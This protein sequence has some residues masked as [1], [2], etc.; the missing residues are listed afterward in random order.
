MKNIDFKR[1]PS[2]IARYRDEVRSRV[3]DELP[4]HVTGWYNQIARAQAEARE[5]ERRAITDQEGWRKERERLLADFRAS[6]GPFPPHLVEIRDEGSLTTPDAVIRKVLFSAAPD[7]WVPA[8][9]YLPHG[10]SAASRVPAIASPCGHGIAGKAAYAKRAIQLVRN[11][12]A[13]ITFDFIGTGERQLVHHLKAL[14]PVSTQHNI[15]GAKLPLAGHTLGWFMLQETLAAATVLERQPEVDPERLGITGA[16][17]GGWTTVHAAALDPRFKVAVPAASVCS[18]RQEVQADDAEQVMF[19]MQRRGL[20]YT[21]LLAFLICPR[22]VFIVANS[23]DIWCLEGTRYAFDEARRLY[24]MAGAETHIAMQVWDKGHA[25]EDDQLTVAIDWFNRWLKGDAAPANVTPLP[26]GAVP[27][28]DDLLITP[29]ENLFDAG[30]PTPNTVFAR[31]ARPA[32]ADDDRPETFLAAIRDA[33][34]PP[35]REPAWIELDRFVP[36]TGLGRRIAFSPEPGLLLPADILVPDEAR[37]VTLLV[38]A[39]DRRDDLDW[40]IEV[41]HAGQVAVRPDLR[42]WGETSPREEWSDW[43]G[44]SQ[45]RYSGKQA[46]LYGLARLTGHNL[47]LDRARDLAALLDVVAQLFPGLPVSLWGRRQGA[48][49]ALYAAVTDTRI[50]R[51][52]MERYLRSYR[53]LMEAELPVW[54]VDGNVERILCAGLDIPDLLRAYRG[55]LNLRDPLDA[56]MRPCAT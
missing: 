22:P 19:G 18:F 50:V 27:A 38:D 24:A 44:W 30:Y 25:Y 41:M 35:R 56:L 54:P 42:G 6:I 29:Q 1:L 21:D 16:S 51:L 14:H 4:D 52:T 28:F 11:G 31:H 45:N 37:G 33:V 47:V 55:E 46:R 15:A 53:D 5:T 10:A 40:Q 49:P 26:D 12:Y 9:I 32:R 17:G 48:L 20:H 8:N 7:N 36:G 34:R 2:P 23:R 13:V 3:G 43:E 39:C